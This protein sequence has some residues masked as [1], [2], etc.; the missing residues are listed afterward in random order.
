[1]ESLN[2]ILLTNHKNKYSI[3]IKVFNEYFKRYI[4]TPLKII[5]NNELTDEIK[6]NNSLIII[7]DKDNLLIKEFINNNL[8]DNP[9][10]EQEYSFM[11]GKSPYNNEQRI[12]M[13]TGNDYNGVLYGVI[14]LINIYFGEKIFTQSQCRYQ[15]LLIYKFPFTNAMTPYKR[16]SS[17]NFLERGGWTWGMCIYD[18]KKYFINMLK[19]KLNLIVIWNDYVPRNAKEIIK[20]AHKCG[21]KVIFGFSWGWED[22]NAIITD[23]S[24]EE[25]KK[26]WADKIVNIYKEQYQP[27]NID[28]IYFQT[29]T[30]RKENIV[31]NQIVAKLATS[32]VNYIANELFKVEPN[33]RLQFGLHDTSIKN[34][35]DY[36]K[37]LDSRIEIIHED[38]GSVPFN[39]LVNE[40]KDFNETM[41]FVKKMV[42]LR[43]N[44]KTGFVLKGF[45]TLDWDNFKHHDENLVIGHAPKAFI[46]EKMKAKEASW[47]LLQGLWMEGSKFTKD[48]LETIKNN[49]PST[50]FQLLIEDAP[51]DA[52][53]YYPI[54]LVAEL[55]WDLDSTLEE[56]QKRTANS[57]FT[58]FAK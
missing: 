52:R 15:S 5:S 33:L 36:L 9:T 47:R 54:M 27:L 6:N 51:I 49:N 4:K 25:N 41:E 31:N 3:G 18:Y 30:E 17:P 22:K 39:Y 55:L 14:D 29:F 44:E 20:F 40:N 19:M 58:Y 23:F 21:I 8:L 32:W 38:C 37:E 10:K 56:I 35:T 34:D 2:W 12:I 1:M 42:N 13:V 50:S 53:V 11:V 45:S 57:P 28:G 46:K 48:M 7:D 26:I 16:H 24:K 43:T